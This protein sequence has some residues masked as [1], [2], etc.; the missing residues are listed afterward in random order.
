MYGTGKASMD[1]K[2]MTA[3]STGIFTL[4]YET[5]EYG[6]D[7]SGEIIITRRDVSD[8]A[9]PQFDDTMKPGYVSVST[10]SDATLVVQYLP[11]RYIRPWKACISIKVRDGSLYPG[12]KIY[13]KYGNE[14]GPGYRIQTFPEAEHI[15]RVLVDCAGSGDFYEIDESPF[16]NIPGGDIHS[17]EICAPS[18]VKPGKNFSILVRALDS[19]GNIAEKF[20]GEV[21]VSIG[22]YDHPVKLKNGYREI[23]ECHLD[24]EGI[25]ILGVKT[26]AGDIKGNSNPIICSPDANNIF[27]G[28]M[29]GQTKE[30][31]GTGTPDLYFS[32][33]RDKAYMDFTGWQGNDFQI[34][35]ETWSNINKK[36]KEYNDP[37]NFVCFLGY[38]W[39]G[40]TPMGGDHNIYFLGDDEKIHRSYHWQIGMNEQDD[41]C[42]NPLPELWEQFKGRN[43]VMAIPHVGG[44][45]ANFD[46][47]NPEFISVVEI[48]SHHGTFEWFFKEALARGYKPGIIAA[49]D[50]HSCRPGLSFPTEVSSRGGFVSFD[51]KGGYTAVFTDDLTRK[52]IWNAI[53]SRHCYATSG[54]RI[55]A[56]VT[57]GEHVMGD[58]FSLTSPPVLNI[59]ITGTAGIKNL[60]VMRNLDVAFDLN[61]TKP[62]DESKIFIEWSGVRVKS[63]AKKTIWKGTIGVE[64]GT[65]IGV[66]EYTGQRKGKRT[67]LLS[68]NLL[69]FNSTTSGDT[70][71]IVITMIKTS[72]TV[73]TFKS[74]QIQFDFK[75][76]DLSDGE[77]I[78]NAGGVNL[79]VRVGHPP[80]EYN[81]S[82][83]L[84]FID[85]NI[86]KGLNAYWIKVVQTNGHML[87]TSPMYINYMDQLLL[88]RYL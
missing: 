42:R 71:G 7:D 28:D 29:H 27:W 75:T 18:I 78:H 14:S 66:E 39:S 82:V 88:Y 51:V 10:D 47:Y 44:R 31:V 1:I 24:K 48:H 81:N 19:W 38:E 59:D 85:A 5:G 13:I 67:E 79:E 55:I 26:A 65:I 64:H 23:R 58:E 12:E 68:G 60:Y 8:S 21:F 77:I 11:S 84:R 32:F 4:I 70:D 62:K 54:E 52:G 56:N 2:E 87:W 76:S 73:I 6:I 30:T 22:G 53:K 36:V 83:H 16:I 37:G 63:R 25:N 80:A 43:D 40:T 61:D 9:I 17:I 57:C 35:D 34:T 46:Y 33:A 74:D 86:E 50:D 45:Y 3:G 41:T 69:K 15:F 49:S 20:S 72:E